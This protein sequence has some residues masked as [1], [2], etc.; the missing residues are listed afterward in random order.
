MMIASLA[1]LVG[2]FVMIQVMTDKEKR[3]EAQAEAMQRS[4]GLPR[5]AFEFDTEDEKK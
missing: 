4:S 5:A 3:R 2:I 1:V